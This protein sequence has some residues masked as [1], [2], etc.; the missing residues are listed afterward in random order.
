GTCANA[1]ASR[2]ASTT[3]LTRKTA[4]AP[5]CSTTQ[6]EPLC[7]ARKSRHPCSLMSAS[8]VKPPLNTASSKPSSSPLASGASGT[9]RGPT[10][11][12]PA[13]P[14]VPP[15][16]ASV[17]SA[18]PAPQGQLALHHITVHLL[19]NVRGVACCIAMTITRDD[20]GDC[21]LGGKQTSALNERMSRDTGVSASPEPH[22][23]LRQRTLG[24]S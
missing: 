23:K 3:D 12:P 11:A 6:S 13:A 4:V 21:F 8:T 5:P 7:A 16:S 19:S 22:G 24:Q 15:P 2:A 20:H 17:A 14:P 18:A 1:S 10:A 9:R